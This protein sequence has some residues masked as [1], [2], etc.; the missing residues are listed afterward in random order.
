METYDQLME[1]A[2]ELGIVRSPSVKQYLEWREDSVVAQSEPLDVYIAKM[3]FF[4]QNINRAVSREHG[5]DVYIDEL[6]CYLQGYSQKWRCALTGDLLQFTRG[7]HEFNGQWANPMCCT[8]DRIDPSKH[9]TI[10][11]LQL[12][13]WQANLFKQGFSMHQLKSLVSKTAKTLQLTLTD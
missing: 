12:V 10:E 8:N 9:Y 4:N 2:R 3:R 7:G 11:N 5:W 6:D 1:Q 13:T